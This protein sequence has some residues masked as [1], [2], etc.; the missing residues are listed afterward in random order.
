VPHSPPSS[1]DVA[2]LQRWNHAWRDFRD[3]FGTVWGVRVMER[4]NATAAAH[5]WPVAL[6]WEGFVWRGDGAERRLAEGQQASAEQSLRALLLRFV[7]R[8]WIEL[9]LMAGG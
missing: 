4:M 6:G 3:W 8:D 1:R 2:E 9:R 5:D 7:S